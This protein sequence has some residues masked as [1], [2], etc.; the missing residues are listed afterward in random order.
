[1]VSCADVLKGG[2]MAIIGYLLTT[3]EKV[4]YQEAFSDP[5]TKDETREIA[6]RKREE[7]SLPNTVNVYYIEE[8]EDIDDIL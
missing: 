5:K 8:G 7:L 6:F 1:M 3:C 2:D 4:Y